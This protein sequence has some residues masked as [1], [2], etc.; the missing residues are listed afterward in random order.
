[1]A[2]LS[3]L[4]I[5][6]GL[7]SRLGAADRAFLDKGGIERR[8]GRKETVFRE[9]AEADGVYLVAQGSLKIYKSGPNGHEQIL[10][11]AGPGELAGYRALLAGEAYSASADTREPSRLTYFSKGLFSDL[12]RRSPAAAEAFI[13]ELARELRRTR[14][15]L[16]E[17]RDQDASARLAR[18]LIDLDAQKPG[19]LAVAR[20]ELADMIG[21]A[22]ET[23]SRLLRH[24]SDHHF[25]H[26]QGRKILLTDR[27]TLTALGKQ[28]EAAAN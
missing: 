26:L 13:E 10:R 21:T 23:I 1:M 19:P 4:K 25:V 7:L 22:P 3:V 6:T 11:I 24:F 17:R 9:G 28:E 8:F 27:E 5:S 20:L 16:L 2:C 12:F 15:R 18:C 14:E